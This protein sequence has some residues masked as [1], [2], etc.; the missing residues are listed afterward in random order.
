MERIPVEG[1]SLEGEALGSGEPV[2][3]IHGSILADAWAPLLKE[4]SL[5]GRYRLINYHRRGFSGSVHH[6]GPFDIA[7]QAADARAVLEHFGIERAHVVGH[8][9]GGTTALQLA[10]DAPSKVHSLGLL[11]P[12]LLPLIPSGPAF[13]EGIAPLGA[14]F[15]AGDRVTATDGFMQAVIGADYRPVLDRAL[16][17]GWFERAVADLHTFFPVEVPALTV[18]DFSR[19]KAKR[20]RQPKLSV[21]GA[22]SAPMFGEVHSVIIELWPDAETYIL[23]GATH[24]LQMQNP[25]G[26]AEALVAFL[27]KHPMPA[28]K[29]E[30]ASTA[31][32]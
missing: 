31:A 13:L 32:R 29:S 22:D 28:R 1:G 27:V 3:L 24:G 5:A 7:A 30:L 21:L 18:W 9:Y 23:P 2:L 11:E 19:E 25:R 15:D 10:L 8:S 14:A 20:I 26:L 16:P 4:A 17:A 12:G 6:T